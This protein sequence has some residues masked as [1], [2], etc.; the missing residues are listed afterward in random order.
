MPALLSQVLLCLELIARVYAGRCFFLYES[1]LRVH[2]ARVP[3]RGHK[4][5]CFARH[6]GSVSAQLDAPLSDEERPEVLTLAERMQSNFQCV[7]YGSN[8]PNKSQEDP[9]KPFRNGMAGIIFTGACSKPLGNQW[10]SIKGIKLIQV[11]VP[12]HIG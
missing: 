12:L 3:E 9:L 1:I 10:I 5:G 6:T 11:I 2:D 4:S 7:Q 8:D